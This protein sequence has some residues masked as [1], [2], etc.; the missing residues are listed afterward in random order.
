MNRMKEIDCEMAFSKRDF[1]L[2]ESGRFTYL[3]ALP[4]RERTG[5]P[6]GYLNFEE[7]DYFW[8]ENIFKNSIHRLDELKGFRLKPFSPFLNPE[9]FCF[10]A[11]KIVKDGGHYG[12]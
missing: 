11:F 6:H 1:F 10:K 12:L 9:Y 8:L 4:V 3:I 2:V 7:G 5:L